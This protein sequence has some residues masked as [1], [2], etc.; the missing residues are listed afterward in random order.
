MYN[1]K[2]LSQEYMENADYNLTEYYDEPIFVEYS[3]RD[4]DDIQKMCRR[5]SDELYPVL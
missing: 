1:L 3:D 2:V 4:I 5:L